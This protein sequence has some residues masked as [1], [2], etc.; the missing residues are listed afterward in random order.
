ML[1]CP[2][3]L[4]VARLRKEIESIYARVA[5]DPSGDFHFHRGADYAASML[6]YDAAELSALPAETPA[7]FAGVANP[8][9]AGKPTAGQVVVDI[10]SGAGTDALLAATYVGPTGRV[11]GI[12]PTDNMLARARGSAAK[13][14]VAHVE[15]RK[16]TGESMPVDSSSVD[17]V[18]S[19]GVINLAPDK[20]PVFREIAR[21]L[22]PGG[23]LQLADIVV[24]SELSEG[25]RRDIDLWTG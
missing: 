21:V 2:V 3:D 25:I 12:D 23:R 19:N 24:A 22:K 8:F 18:I 9:V 10:G 4:D 7:S 5:D 14:G 20:E 13:L 1:T 15:F 16:G 6:A 17:L 11:I